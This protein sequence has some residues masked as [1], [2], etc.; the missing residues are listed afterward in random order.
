MTT[1]DLHQEAEGK[2]KALPHAMDAE[3]SVL[4]AALFDPEAYHFAEGLEGRHFYEPAH[5]RAWEA[6]STR[7]EAGRGAD[8][9]SVWEVM[10][11]DP[12]LQELG[13]LAYLADLIDKAPPA[14]S[15]K[16]HAELIIDRAVRRSIIIAS[17][18]FTALAADTSIPAWDHL[19]E[20]EQTLYALSEKGP[21]GGGF[22]SFGSALDGAMDMAAAAYD[23]RG[24]VAG[25][26][27]GLIDL[28]GML[29]GLHPSDLV[30]L[31]G[32]PSM[33]K[34]ALAT[35][36]AFSAARTGAEV[37]FYSLEMSHEQLALRILADVSGVSS[38]RI[39]KGKIDAS[40]F[41]R[42]RDARDEIRQAP[43]HIDATGGLPIGKLAARARRRHR[44]HKLS[45]I[46]VDYLQ[47]VTG[48]AASQ[49]A[50]QG[51]GGVRGHHGPEGARQGAWR[52]RAGPV[53]T[54]QAGREPRGQTAPAQRP[55]GVRLHRAGRRRGD[56]RLPRGILPGPH[57]APRRHRRAPEVVRGHEQGP[58][59]AEVII[60]KQRHGPI[61]TV[62][63]SFNA[64][65][66]KFGNLARESRFDG[67]GATRDFSE[68]TGGRE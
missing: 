44:K 31:A 9:V 29:G 34:T 33:G 53:A 51:A 43:L 11:D 46:V 15:A 32:R 67:A 38:D 8:P 2:G 39:R 45:L 56:V 21:A 14:R 61:G 1:L 55:A 58:G 40:E 13:G 19:A 48:S 24:E 7:I 4:G 6:I 25:L 27:T 65:L 41:G 36:I 5:Q 35:N 54:V 22:V 64:D 26:S 47:L 16:D 52:A 66:T 30:I 59:Q 42:L 17:T 49:R 62:R 3:Q 12:A 23:R 63:L 10:K 50:G 57:R 18:D 28:D 37:A 20:A 60:G 68:P